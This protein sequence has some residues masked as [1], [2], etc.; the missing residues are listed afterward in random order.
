ML[1]AQTQTPSSSWSGVKRCAVLCGSSCVGFI[2]L[3]VSM[4]LIFMVTSPYRVEYDLLESQSPKLRAG[5]LSNGMKYQILQNKLK[6]ERFASF[7]AVEVGSM[8]E[9]E[10]ERGIA[11]MVEHMAFDSTR[12]FPGRA[13]LWKKVLDLGGVFNAFTSFRNT[14]YMLW[15]LP[16]ASLDDALMVHTNQLFG[17]T[18]QDS[19][20]LNLE[21]GAVLS[22]G[23]FRNESMSLALEAMLQ[24][25]G[26]SKWRPASRMPIGTIETIESWTP[27]QVSAFLGKWYR[28]AAVTLILVG[29]FPSLETVEQKLMS[30]E[31]GKIQP[32]YPGSRDP[33]SRPALGPIRPQ[34]SIFIHPVDG[35]DATWISLFVSRPYAEHRRK[36]NHF[37]TETVS[38]LFSVL[39]VASTL[40]RYAIMYPSASELRLAA[41]LYSEEYSFG[42][43]LNLWSVIVP[44]PSRGSTWKQDFVAALIELRRMADDGPDDIVVTLLLY[45]VHAIFYVLEAFGD[46]LDHMTMAMLVLGDM[47]PHYPFL[48]FT[49]QKLIQTQFLDYGFTE[50]AKAHIKAEARMLW[51]CLTDGLGKG[52]ATLNVFVDDKTYSSASVKDQEWISASVLGSLIDEVA[53]MEFLGES[54]LYSLLSASGTGGKDS[55][56]TPKEK[57]PQDKVSLP[58]TPPK[59]AGS[60][61]GITQYTLS[62][63]IPLNLKQL[64]SA[65]GA[66][67]VSVNALRTVLRDPMESAAACF[68]IN[69]YSQQSSMD[70]VNGEVLR[71]KALLHESCYLN[72]FTGEPCDPSLFNYESPL[73]ALRTSIED[74]TYDRTQTMELAEKV[75]SANLVRQRRASPLESLPYVMFQEENLSPEDIQ[76][77]DPSLVNAWVREMFSSGSV[78]I[79]VVGTFDE[80]LL[81]NAVNRAFGSLPSYSKSLVGL[82]V[83]DAANVDFF[84]KVPAWN[85]FPS[86]RSCDVHSVSP[87]RAFVAGRVP[88]PSYA[89]LAPYNSAG[90]ISYVDSV[91][92]SALFDSMRRDAGFTY[93]VQVQADRS[94]VFPAQSYYYL[95]WAP[96]PQNIDASVQTANQ[97]LSGAIWDLDMPKKIAK[98]VVMGLSGELNA[99]DVSMWLSIM[100]GLSLKSPVSWKAYTGSVRSIDT[101]DKVFEFQDLEF[102]VSRTVHGVIDTAAIVTVAGES[103]CL[104]SS[105]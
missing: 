56:V 96:L 71:A 36:F 37:R 75:F 60:K 93:F 31:I 45:V 84:G 54:P 89:S 99:G 72:T 15:E 102:I 20:N 18:V 53:G 105:L 39:Y 6:A 91:I 32:S 46:S 13:G 16:V 67:S 35:L 10:S 33:F 88:A 44:G 14:V 52:E 64:P 83:Y 95:V 70:C 50:S 63:G 65:N 4:V 80:Q 49:Q 34:K 78:E 92:R 40:S 19:K 7:A 1:Q 104:P 85:N 66:V 8:D 12:D 103:T 61:N 73:L 76:R 79:N 69:A 82:D 59:L 51:N 30:A 28:P 26:G 9:D 21:K 43:G 74:F 86:H 68:L 87:N 57:E 94:L 11:H 27:D 29:D 24:N 47:D 25:H 23:R 98:S 22:E 3:L 17:Q 62:N 100:Q 101:F 42:T 55:L 48:D 58:S 5:T 41:V 38:R 90:A 2:V 77:L 97:T 81:V